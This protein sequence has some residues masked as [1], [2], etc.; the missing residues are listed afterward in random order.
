MAN[1]PILLSEEYVQNC[2]HSY[3]KSALTQAKAERLLDT[4]VLSSAEGDLMITGECQCLTARA[5]RLTSIQD[6]HYACTLP[7]CALPPT[8][9][10]CLCHVHPSRLHHQ[11]T[12]RQITVLSHSD[13]SWKYGLRRYR[14]SRLSRR[15]TSTTLPA[16]SAV[17]PLSLAH[18]TQG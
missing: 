5:S 10:V 8:H 2:F 14:T 12:S 17:F 13:P 16:S 9:H 18:R 11:Q 6:L 3:L 7:R 15:S 4:D 1:N